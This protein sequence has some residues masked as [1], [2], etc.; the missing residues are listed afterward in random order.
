MLGY[1]DKTSEVVDYTVGPIVTNMCNDH[2]YKWNQLKANEF[3]NRHSRN[4]VWFSQFGNNVLCKVCHAYST[5]YCTC[6]LKNILQHE[7]LDLKFIIA[8][9][10][11]A[12]VPVYDTRCVACTWK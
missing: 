10:E 6:T 8:I 11:S 4:Y 9:V 3:S 12:V 2:L 7:Q 1:Q 5:G